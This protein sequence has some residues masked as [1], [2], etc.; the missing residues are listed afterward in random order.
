MTPKNKF[1]IGWGISQR[2]TRSASEIPM[3]VVIPV[4]DDI[5]CLRSNN[6]FWQ[7]TSPKTFCVG[8]KSGRTPC[9]G[10]LTYNFLMR[11]NKVFF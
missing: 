5:V 2:N 11:K 4:V 7:I 3:Y 1:P 8:D 6:V 9:Q 10:N